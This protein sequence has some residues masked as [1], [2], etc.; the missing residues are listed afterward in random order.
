M[1]K[2]FAFTVE[3]DGITRAEFVTCSELTKE[4][5]KMEYRAGGRLNPTKEAGL[6]NI[7]DITLERG[8]T[9]DRE[10]ADWVE[11]V[12]DTLTGKATVP[13]DQYKRNGDIVQRDRNGDEVRRYRFFGAFPST[14]TVGNWDNNAEEFVMETLVL[15]LDS[16]KEL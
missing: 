12:V 7:S 11:E 6:V 13:G 8:K 10:F 4:I 16:F 2:K 14:K 5:G 15:S 3:I 1:D 9:A